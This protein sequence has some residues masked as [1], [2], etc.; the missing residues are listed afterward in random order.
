MAEA[1][2]ASMRAGS[3]RQG[4]LRNGLFLGLALSGGGSRAANFSAEVLFEL[5]SLGFASYITAISSVS[6]GSITA[7]YY[8]LHGNDPALWNR[9]A[10]RTLL[11]TDFEGKLVRRTFLPHNFV[12]TLATD[13]DRTDL[14]KEIL[15]ETLFKGKTFADLGSV[16]PKLLI[17][18]SSRTHLGQIFVFTAETF[19]GL[20]ASRLASYPLSHAVAASAAFPG[21]FNN[22]TLR[23]FSDPGGSD[24]PLHY[25]HLFDGGVADNLG[26]RTVLQAARELYLNT[27]GDPERTPKACE[28]VLIDAGQSVFAEGYGEDRYRSDTRKGF[29]YIVDS[30]F[31]KATNSLFR[32][33]E[34]LRLEDEGI[35]RNKRYQRIPL[36]RAKSFRLDPDECNDDCERRLAK[37]RHVDCGVWRVAIE[38]VAKLDRSGQA[39]AVRGLVPYLGSKTEHGEHPLLIEDYARTRAE[40]VV[41]THDIYQMIPM[42]IIELIPTGLKLTSEFNYPSELLQ[43]YLANA[44]R[45]LVRGDAESL[46]KFCFVIAS[47][48]LVG[49]V[50]DIVDHR[51]IEAGLRERAATGDEGAQVAI[52][53]GRWREVPEQSSMRDEAKARLG[54]LADQ[55][56]AL[57]Q[58]ELADVLAAA[59]DDADDEEIEA[60]LRRAAARGL[61]S[62]QRKLAFAL[63][64]GRRMPKDIDE[65]RKWLERA[66]R[67]DIPS[68][69]MLGLMY[70]SGIGVT[71]D[72]AIAR[73]LF[74]RS[75]AAGDAVAHCLLGQI[76][77]RGLGVEA[78]SVLAL[79]HFYLAEVQSLAG[80][81]ASATLFAAN[82]PCE[83]L[84]A[85]T[86][87]AGRLDREQ[88]T[89]AQT[90]VRASLRAYRVLGALD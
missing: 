34:R 65:A 25:V 14:M 13:F 42:G 6:G 63:M 56:S 29:D 67:M 39:D 87:V 44:A 58:E 1:P 55:G 32:A 72:Y 53:A 70:L 15:D 60:L 69:N 66:A 8:A 24:V 26:I 73:Q 71:T 17:N 48:Q 52:A 4:Q 7:A 3:Y 20:A 75:S 74:E 62:A 89:R 28:I 80:A 31:A 27:A 45:T 33:K 68:N 2:R 43:Q 23:D 18:A 16:G 54:P 83:P 49:N 82:L 5:Q 59:S 30:N 10:V 47:L 19:H 78:N 21:V 38:N 57:A 85:I 84:V 46:R 86:R 12:L 90:A 64:S 50:C 81:P 37:V 76:Y 40:F 79:T 11:R 22:V 36:F 41:A 77:E 88:I 9:G 51:S 35:D 61:T